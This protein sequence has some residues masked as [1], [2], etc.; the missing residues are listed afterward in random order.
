MVFIVAGTGAEQN[1]AVVAP[2]I[3]SIAWL[4]TGPPVL[5]SIEQYRNSDSDGRFLCLST[6]FWTEIGH[7]G[8]ELVSFLFLASSFVRAFPG[9]QIV[10][11]GLLFVA[12]VS[13]FGVY[14][15]RVAIQLK[16]NT[17]WSS[18]VLAC[19]FFNLTGFLALSFATLAYIINYRF[20]LSSLCVHTYGYYI[21]TFPLLWSVI[22]QLYSGHTS[23]MV[24]NP[25][26]EHIQMDTAD[27]ESI[28]V[29]L[30]ENDGF[31]SDTD[32]LSD[33]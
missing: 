13:G 14:T 6:R 17:Q 31:P 30:N 2:I 33:N 1:A 21:G 22:I 10:S 27:S 28:S 24:H 9:K 5:L 16:H 7:Y 32:D 12:A 8:S 15:V 23:D 25:S 4:V 20:L 3:G 18:Y 29:D 26:M 19:T 11:D